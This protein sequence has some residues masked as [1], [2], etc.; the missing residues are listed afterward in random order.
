MLFDCAK[1]LDKHYIPTR[2]P[3]GF[4]SGAPTDFYTKQEGEMAL[5]CASEIRKKHP[6][7]RRIIWFGSWINGTYSTGSDVDLCIVVSKSKKHRRNRITDFLPKGFPVGMD[8]FVYTSRELSKL[9][10]SHSAWFEAIQ[11]G[12]ELI[13]DR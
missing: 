2:Y 9:E 11:S 13:A 6:E 1:T 4:D 5:R 8:I 3:N 12:I 10:S 7:V